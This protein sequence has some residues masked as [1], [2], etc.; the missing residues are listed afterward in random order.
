MK[1]TDVKIRLVKGKRRL[2]AVASITLDR[3]LI[4]NDIKI[5]Q[6]D[7]R[8]CVAFPENPY[9]SDRNHVQ[10]VIVPLS[11]EIREN[12]ENRILG[13]YEEIISMISGEVC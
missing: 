3:A 6:T 12:F 5:I 7:S 8:L 1:I 4:I 10:Y 13:R 2:K 11:M 9:A